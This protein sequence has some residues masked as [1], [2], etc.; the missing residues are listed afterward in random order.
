MDGSH[1]KTVPEK[2]PETVPPV[3]VVN[4]LTL[5]LP[6]PPGRSVQSTVAPSADVTT[7][8]L[9][10]PFVLFVGK[11]PIVGSYT[12]TVTYPPVSLAPVTA[13]LLELAWHRAKP[14]QMKKVVFVPLIVTV[15]VPIGG[16][17]DGS[18]TPT[19]ATQTYP[20][21]APQIPAVHV[22]PALQVW[23]HPPQLLGSELVLR[24][25]P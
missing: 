3:E 17:P 19:P 9:D 24:Q 11:D 7:S 21:A 25:I 8:A 12:V 18:I 5:M 10:S 23:P 16:V 6:A 1:S 4:A 14:G 22:S 13:K 2:V 15:R 20:P